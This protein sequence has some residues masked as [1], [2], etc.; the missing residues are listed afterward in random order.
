MSWFVL[1]YDVLIL[2][3][4]VLSCAIV[5]CCVVVSNIVLCFVV[6]SCFVFRVLCWLCYVEPYRLL[7]VALSRLVLSIAVVLS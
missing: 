5:S 2:S 1:S 6:L 7:I 4:L 3:C